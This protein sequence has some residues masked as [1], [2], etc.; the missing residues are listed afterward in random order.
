M[1]NLFRYGG[2]YEIAISSY[3]S[4]IAD[5]PIRFG[6]S[7]ADLPIRFARQFGATFNSADIVLG[8]VI[9]GIVFYYLIERFLK[10]SPRQIMKMVPFVGKKL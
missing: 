7:I 6:S 5:L 4:S 10:K 8:T 9:G 1:T 2:P 3:G